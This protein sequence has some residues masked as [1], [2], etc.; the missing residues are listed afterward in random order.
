M[1]I[2]PARK[3]LKRQIIHQK[4]RIAELT[5]KLRHAH[6]QDPES[7]DDDF[8]DLQIGAQEV[9]D[10]GENMVD[11]GRVLDLDHSPTSPSTS[12]PGIRP[13]LVS[14]IVPKPHTSFNSSPRPLRRA[15]SPIRSQPVQHTASRAPPYRPPPVFIS[16]PEQRRKTSP[17]GSE[18]P[19]VLEIS[20]RPVGKPSSDAG[21]GP[22]PLIIEHDDGSP[23]STSGS[24]TTATISHI[25]SLATTVESREFRVQPLD[26]GHKRRRIPRKHEQESSSSSRIEIS[27]RDPP[28]Q[29]SPIKRE[30]SSTI[31]RVEEDFISVGP[32]SYL[33][34][35]NSNR[36]LIPTPGY[37]NIDHR[38]IFTTP[39]LDEAL[40]FNII[41]LAYVQEL[42]LIPEPPDDEE[43]VWFN[44]G[45]GEKRKS[46]GEVVIYWS[47][48]VVNRKPFRVRCLVY[49]HNI[50]PL[51]FGKPFLERK[52]HYWGIDDGMEERRVSYEESEL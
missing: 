49:A 36:P 29:P 41:S 4:E 14:G 10:L 47:D 44:F 31:A 48:G 40:D 39:L 17:S 46:C 20:E 42:G 15:R 30:K 25:S 50:R 19:F 51:M 1:L 33:L 52:K 38:A 27:N 37:I 35:L 11:Q 45:N 24:S 21:E 5:E 13:N 3:R 34:N 8:F 6:E 28:D 2:A 43:P 12:W 32:K 9:A 26:L 22:S 23:V 16:D 18:A 7:H